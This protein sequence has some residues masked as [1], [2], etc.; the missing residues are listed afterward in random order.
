MDDNN[1]SASFIVTKNASDIAGFYS[2]SPAM[3]YITYS[4]GLIGMT[5]N[6]FVVVIIINTSAMRKKLTNAYITNQSVIDALASLLLIFSVT[7]EDDGRTYHT[8]LDDLKCRI[9]FTRFPSW[10]LFTSSTYNLIMLTIERYLSIIHPIWHKMKFTK[11]MVIASIL[12]VWLF[13]ASFNAALLFPTSGLTANGKCRVLMFWPEG[14]WQN[15][16]GVV[17]IFILYFIPLFIFTI[18][19]TRIFIKLRQSVRSAVINDPARNFR[20]PGAVTPIARARNNVLKT[21]FIV[22]CS[23]IFCWTWNEIYFLIFNVGGGEIDF[24]SAF[25]N[26]TVVMIF[27]NCCINPFIYVAKYEEFQ[28]ATKRIFRKNVIGIDNSNSVEN[29]TS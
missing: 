18:L 20:Q 12:F 4:I 29:N 16:V 25:Y 11:K 22:V 21:L 1:T 5:G 17:A 13:G 10:S 27:M 2:T 23:F 7:F 6:I 24:T 26:F 9:W 14:H 19:Y 3:R 28:K 15:A 8:L